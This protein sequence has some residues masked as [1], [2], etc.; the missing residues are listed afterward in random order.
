MGDATSVTRVREIEDHYWRAFTSGWDS[1]RHAR[2]LLLECLNDAAKKKQ[3]LTLVA[4]HL[5]GRAGRAGTQDEEILTA[6]CNDPNLSQVLPKVFEVMDTLPWH[7]VAETIAR[8][9]ALTEVDAVRY[10]FAF[11]HPEAARQ[12]ED[13]DITRALA[14][15][16]RPAGRPSL[17]SNERPQP[18]KWPFLASLCERIGLGRTTHRTLQADWGLWRRRSVP[19]K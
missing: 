13:A 4:A 16:G 17:A 7:D 11:S 1:R 19:R 8:R 14:A 3:I 2:M 9:P 18:K 10:F 15:W 12:L 6:I 5:R